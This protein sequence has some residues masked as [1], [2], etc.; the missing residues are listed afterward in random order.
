MYI[1]FEITDKSFVL[2]SLIIFVAVLVIAFI[3]YITTKDDK[4][5]PISEEE[6]FDNE[7]PKE[8]FENIKPETKEQQEAKDEL[9]RVFKQMSED[10]E[11]KEPKTIID[12]FEKEQEATAVIS[13]QELLRQAEEKR[14]HPNQNTEEK[15]FHNSEVISPIFGVQKTPEYHAQI[16][17]KKQLENLDL[18][19][20]KESA[21][22]FLNS[23]K[24]FRK[25]L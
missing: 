12:T 18:A 1:L 23:L 11:K 7:K 24:E 5:E 6:R 3:I 9:E 15:K 21:S 25:N 14:K 19:Y 22:D 2:L 4:I 13:Y 20:E 8:F 10:I 17:E 16:K